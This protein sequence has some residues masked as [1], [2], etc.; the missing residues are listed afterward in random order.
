MAL[1]PLILDY[2]VLTWFFGCECLDVALAGLT[3][4]V[5]RYYGTTRPE[6]AQ[7][8]PEPLPD[9][10]FLSYIWNFE[11]IHAPKFVH[12]LDL[13]GSNVPVTVLRS[14]NEINRIT[15]K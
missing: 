2:H 5:L 1:H 8:C 14:H 7:S 9:R 10:E 15:A 4:R 11:K 12:N 13:Y 3:R 6:M